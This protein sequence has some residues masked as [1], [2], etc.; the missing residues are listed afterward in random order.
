MMTPMMQYPPIK[1][2]HDITNKLCSH[3]SNISSASQFIFTMKIFAAYVLL[4]SLLI[5]SD[6]E[7]KF[8][9][10]TKLL[11]KATASLVASL[12]LSLPAFADAIP[13]VGTQ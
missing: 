5:I 8:L 3:Y 10:N 1:T 13:L 4:I 6:S 12:S 2:I 7:S 9:I 11:R